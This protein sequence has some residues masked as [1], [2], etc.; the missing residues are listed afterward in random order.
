MPSVSIPI[1]FMPRV[2]IPSVIMPS[3][4]ML[5][6]YANCHFADCQWLRRQ[7]HYKHFNGSF[8]ALEF[9]RLVPKCLPA[10]NALAYHN[11]SFCLAKSEDLALIV[12]Q[13]C[14][15]PPRFI[16]IGSS[17]WIWLSC[18]DKNRKKQAGAINMKEVEAER[19]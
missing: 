16:D 13:L 18:S 1:V 10:T 14:I 2:I 11:K 6:H 9:R 7:T 19:V 17:S 4:I 8:K 3:V 12:S 15:F 5:C